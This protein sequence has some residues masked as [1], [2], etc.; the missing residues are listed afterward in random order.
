MN[1]N[2]ENSNE[3]RLYPADIVLMHMV[4]FFNSKNVH[5]ESADA[6]TSLYEVAMNAAWEESINRLKQKGYLEQEKEIPT[7][8]A[9]GVK[10]Y[11]KLTTPFMKYVELHGLYSFTDNEI[12][13]LVRRSMAELVKRVKKSDKF[14][15]RLG[16]FINQHLD[17][18]NN[19][20]S[21]FQGSYEEAYGAHKME[22]ELQTV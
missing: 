13:L 17:K 18:W 10:K 1:N 8:T 6:A 22:E 4:G 7:F 3:V 14:L 15:M 2:F 11:E 12:L 9:K 5:P 19:L 16:A 21:E 20:M